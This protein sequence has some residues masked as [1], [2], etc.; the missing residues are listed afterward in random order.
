MFSHVGVI[1]GFLGGKNPVKKRNTT[2]RLLC[3]DPDLLSIWVKKKKMYL[4]SVIASEFIYEQF[5]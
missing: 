2:F 3:S 1:S 5:Q 4:I